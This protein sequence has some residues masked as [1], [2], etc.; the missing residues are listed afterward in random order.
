MPEPWKTE[1]AKFSV[2]VNILGGLWLGYVI[3]FV[4]VMFTYNTYLQDCNRYTEDVACN[5]LTDAGCIWR[6]NQC[7][8]PDFTSVN[9]SLYETQGSCRVV[10]GCYWK[11]HKQECAHLTGW[12]AEQQGLMA[13]MQIIGA[14]VSSA[15]A[16]PMTDRIGRKLAVA[17]LGVVSLLSCVL[18]AVGWSMKE[19]YAMLVVAE[20]VA[21]LAAGGVSVVCPMYVGEMADR[22]LENTIGI[23]FQIA[24]TFGILLAATVGLILDPRTDT[25]N[26]H[27]H[28]QRRLQFVL[29]VQWLVAVAFMPTAYFMP[30]SIVW[31]RERRRSCDALIPRDDTPVPA[32]DATTAAA[33]QPSLRLF[34]RELLLPLVVGVFLGAGQQLTG[35]NA[36]MVYGPQLVGAVGLQPLVG[37]FVIML[38][39]FLTCLVS[40]PLVARYAPRKMYIGST[41]AATVTCALTGIAVLPGVFEANGTAQHV[42]SGIGILGFVAAFENGIGPCFYV[43]AQDTFP[44]EVRSAGCSFT[45]FVQFLFNVMI[46]WGYPNAQTGI[47]GGPSGDQNFGMAVCFFIFSG[48]GFITALFLGLKM[49]KSNSELRKETEAVEAGDDSAAFD[50]IR[51]GSAQ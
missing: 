36:I 3:G 48:I 19:N 39:N 47:S 16:G 21:G 25:A 37:N 43:L 9:C 26:P 51:A 13:G 34:R 14:T 15:V 11:Y 12:T 5:A 24:V 18:F 33:S 49:P 31:L 41:I 1:G 8:F 17:V 28:L 46:N 42:L 40:I 22:T 2:I 4:P 35:I 10:S 20:F 30:E 44:A 7:D 27:A 50:Y 32:T 29:L 45:L 38:W 23:F 6:N